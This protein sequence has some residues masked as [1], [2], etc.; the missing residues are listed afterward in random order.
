[1]IC[2]HYSLFA[3]ERDSGIV[4]QDGMFI[5]I[6][7]GPSQSRIINGGSNLTLKHS[8]GNDYSYCGYLE[9]GYYFSKYFGLST[10]IGFDSYNSLLTL[11]DYQSKFII[12]D[13]ENESYERRVS[14]TAIREVQEIGFLSVPFSINLRIPFN[15]TIGLF[16]EPGV[17]IIV[18]VIKNYNSIGTFTYKG[19]FPAYNVLLENLPAYGFPSNM[20]SKTNGNLEIKPLGFNAMVSAGFDCFIVNKLQIA[21]V[22]CYNRSL[23]TISGYT[24]PELFQLSSDPDQINSLMGGT[25]ESTAQSIGLKIGVRYFLK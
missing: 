22:V 8:Y 5:G 21:V 10:G 20:N 15:K 12:N 7:F 9:T 17:N 1:M 18:P 23:S 13:K 3:Q 2:Y 4:K 24:S 16:L 19:Y 11:D 6:S 25:T 14:G